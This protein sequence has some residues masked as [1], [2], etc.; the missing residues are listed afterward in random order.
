MIPLNQQIQETLSGQLQSIKPDLRNWDPGDHFKQEL[1][2]DSLDLVEFVAR[3]EQH[4]RIIVPDE[5]L[6][7]MISLEATA[8]YVHQHLAQ[9]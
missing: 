7:Q 8:Q 3:I 2:L 4:Y 5:D 1:G 9:S 6:E